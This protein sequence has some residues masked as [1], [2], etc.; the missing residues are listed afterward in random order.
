MLDSHTPFDSFAQDDDWPETHQELRRTHVETTHYRL[1][2]YGGTYDGG[3]ST[4][5]LLHIAEK[6]EEGA[7][8]RPDSWCV[9]CGTWELQGIQEA[10]ERVLAKVSAPGFSRKQATGKS[11]IDTVDLTVR[12]DSSW[13]LAID[14]LEQPALALSMGMPRRWLIYTPDMAYLQDLLTGLVALFQDGAPTETL[15]EM[16]ETSHWLVPF[17]LESLMP[18][19]IARARRVL[20]QHQQLANS[21]PLPAGE[22]LSLVL[23]QLRN[24]LPAVAACA[25]C[26]Q[27]FSRHPLEAWKNQCLSCYWKHKG[28]AKV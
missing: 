13:R 16:T 3:N 12:F 1:S 26:Q 15:A 28:V 20:A 2:A 24:K 25:S 10:A 27:P 9:V 11:S 5:T 21:L 22:A 4:Q 23:D 8:A 19:D 18:T 6:P 7:R 17:H 14:F